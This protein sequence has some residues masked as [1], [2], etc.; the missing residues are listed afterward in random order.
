MR[1]IFLYL[2]LVFVS[3]TQVSSLDSPTVSIIELKP[4]IAKPAPTAIVTKPEMITA[5]VCHRSWGLPWVGVGRWYRISFNG[6]KQDII[7]HTECGTLQVKPGTRV[8]YVGSLLQR[9]NLCIPDGVG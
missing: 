6:V 7:S 2:V 8:G 1:I 5:T 4:V 9:T 3:V